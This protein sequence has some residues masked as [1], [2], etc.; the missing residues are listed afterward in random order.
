L[1]AVIGR[2]RKQSSAFLV[3]GLHVLLL[4]YVA[5][6]GGVVLPSIFDQLGG[7]TSSVVVYV[8]LSRALFES[9]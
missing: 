8:T 7:L 1:T 2:K 9:L 4:I 3:R 6:V 5:F